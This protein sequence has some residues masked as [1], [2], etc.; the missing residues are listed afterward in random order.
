MKARASIAVSILILTLAGCGNPTAR[1]GHRLN[2]EAE[3]SGSPFRW[4]SESARGGTVL[5]RVM[6]DLPLGETKADAPLK[7]DILS[8]IEQAELSKGRG[9]PEVEEV[10]LLPDGREVWLLQNR[11]H[12][13]AYV[14]GMKPSAQGGTDFSITG[15]NHFRK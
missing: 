7:K 5:T 3:A 13:V 6:I 1:L 10:H 12:G 8:K 14:I 15:P 11:Q 9:V 4:K 2:R